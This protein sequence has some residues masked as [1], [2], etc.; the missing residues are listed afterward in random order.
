[1][2]KI[3]WDLINTGKV[4]SLIDD[5]IVGIVKEQEHDRRSSEMIGLKKI[6]IE[7]E[8]VKKVLD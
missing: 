7:E 2:S 4:T 3:L 6:K 8:K 5:V 1:M